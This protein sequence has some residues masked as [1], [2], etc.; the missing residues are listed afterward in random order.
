LQTGLPV[1][2]ELLLQAGANIDAVDVMRRSPIMWAVLYDRPEVAR[3]LLRCVC[4][5]ASV[6]A[7]HVGAA[8]AA[9]EWLVCVWRGGQAWFKHSERHIMWPGAGQE[10]ANCK[11]FLQ[12]HAVLACLYPPSSPRLTLALLAF[13]LHCRRGAACTRD[14]Q[15]LTPAQLA[16]GRPCSRDAELLTLLA[17]QA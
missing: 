4:A 7:Q 12:G 5:S 3:L 16:A 10:E 17:K 11:V 14:R 8:A 15:G 9:F 6:A 1:L 13:S 2:A